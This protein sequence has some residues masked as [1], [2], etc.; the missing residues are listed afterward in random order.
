M[1]FFDKKQEVMDIELTQYGKRLLAKGRF[2]PEY[3]QFFDDDI[4]YRSE[5]ASFSE[6]QNETE[7]RILLD[8]P[9]LKTRHLTY[10]IQKR[11]V[12]NTERIINKERLRFVPL[13]ENYDPEKQERLLL[14]PLMNQD[15]SKV[16][17][18]RYDIRTVNSK[19]DSVTFDVLT[20]SGIQ[21]NIPIL[22]TRQD[23]II[24][25]DR[26]DLKQP[27]TM[28]AE[29]FID[30]LSEDI[31]FADNSKIQVESQEIILDVQELNCFSGL[32]NF[33]LNVFEV[34]K[35]EDGTEKMIKFENLEEIGMF[36]EIITDDDV[37]EVESQNLKSTNYYKRGEEK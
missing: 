9:R 31:V 15:I 14:Y 8:T 3:Y 5:C 37:K 18:P 25:E 2:R 35:Q 1:T 11:Y 27:S 32:D 30:F 6:H 4:L 29:T 7:D 28:T 16:E 24:K 13:Y 34:V 21:K 33:R 36:F 19:I 10:P 22:N 12:E 26:K 20:G 23:F 17:S